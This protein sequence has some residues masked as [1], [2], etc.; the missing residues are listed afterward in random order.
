MMLKIFGL[1]ELKSDVRGVL[2][3]EMGWRE[4]IWVRELY[5]KVTK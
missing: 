4:G 1:V 5:N 2:I 3:G